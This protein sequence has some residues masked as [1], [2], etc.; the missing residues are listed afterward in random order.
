[1]LGPFVSINY[2]FINTNTGIDMDEYIFTGGLKFSYNYKILFDKY[3]QIFSSDIGYRNITGKTK[4][5]F[6][7][8]VDLISA[9]IGIGSAMAEETRKNNLTY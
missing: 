4:F 2:F 3:S 5:Y 6:S 7:I 8:S 1:M 9:V